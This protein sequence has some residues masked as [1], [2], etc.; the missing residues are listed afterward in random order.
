[1][2][3]THNG[4]NMLAEGVE[5]GKMGTRLSEFG[6]E[7]VHEMN[8]LGM[9]IGVSHLSANGVFH[10]CEISKH[11][12]VSTHQNIQ[13][14][15]KTKLEL[16]EEEV[17]A[18]AK[19]GG[20]M[21]MRYIVGVTPYKLLVDEIE[22]LA[23]TVGVKHIGVGWLGHDKMHPATGAVPGYE[24]TKRQFTGVEA[25]SIY[26]HWDTF[27]QM[28]EERGFKPEEIAMIVGGNFVRVMREVLPAA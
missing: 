9:L 11:P 27:I 25:Q 13:P 2:Q 21:G 23:K 15:L 3:L 12:V 4:R 6:V 10:V 18:I 16:I 8:R 5:G 20:V 28:L 1:M 24:R 22:H 7:C 19:T 17:K 26:E 14:F